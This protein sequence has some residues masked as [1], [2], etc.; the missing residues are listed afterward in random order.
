MLGVTEFVASTHRKCRFCGVT[1]LAIDHPR[2]YWVAVDLCS[3]CD[4]EKR[5]I[6]PGGSPYGATT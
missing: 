1:D 4:A 6:P 2:T 3:G 5:G